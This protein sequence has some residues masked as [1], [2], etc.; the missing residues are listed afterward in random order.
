LLLQWV[1][2]IEIRPARL[3]PLNRG[4]SVV[5]IVIADDYIG[6]AMARVSDY[7]GDLRAWLEHA[8]DGVHVIAHAFT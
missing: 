8:Q 5:E 7:N 1:A 6:I 2:F 4:D 3:G